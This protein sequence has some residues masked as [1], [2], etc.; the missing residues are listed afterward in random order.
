MSDFRQPLTHKSSARDG[1]TSGRQTNT[2]ATV[3]APNNLPDRAEALEA[4][5]NGHI[6]ELAVWNEIVGRAATP[7]PKPLDPEL[8]RLVGADLAKAREHLI[9]AMKLLDA[10]RVQA[11]VSEIHLRT[12]TAVNE[13]D[14]TAELLRSGAPS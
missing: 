8:A 10:N 12:G 6:Q 4:A 9:E 11:G 13:V 7:E 3:P 2:E 14:D 5:D 1:G